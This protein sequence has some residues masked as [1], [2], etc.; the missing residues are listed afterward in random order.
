MTA[1]F[2]KTSLES[3]NRVT[4]HNL[5]S[6]QQSIPEIHNNPITRHS[7]STMLTS[8]PSLLWSFKQW[9]RVLSTI[10]VW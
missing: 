6:V 2:I 10:A 4:A 1:T 3:I 7:L 8:T 5:P 9:P